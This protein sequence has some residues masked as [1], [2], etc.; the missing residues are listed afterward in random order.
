[1]AYH[2]QRGFPWCGR[3]VKR[4]QSSLLQVFCNACAGAQGYAHAFEQAVPVSATAGEDERGALDVFT[5]ERPLE[6]LSVA[7]VHPKMENGMPLHGGSG[8]VRCAR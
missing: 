3:P 2:E 7:S 6:R 4:N 8:N 1:M 5:V